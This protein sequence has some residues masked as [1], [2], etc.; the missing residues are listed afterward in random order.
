VRYRYYVSQALLH[1]KPQ[2]GGAIRRVPA[3]EI[4]A[5]VL[6]G[7]REH[8]QASGAEPGSLPGNDRELI[9]RH[10]ERVTLHP[11]HIKLQLH[12]CADPPEAG[13][14]A[15]MAGG[16]GPAH[17]PA[18]VVTLPWSSPVPAAVK[19]IV[20]VPAHN[21][22]I[23]PGRRDQLLTAIAKAR[24]WVDGVAQGSTSF[25]AIARREGV[26]ERHVRALVP[27]AFVSPRIV[28]ALLKGTAPADLTVTA[29]ARARW[30]WA[31]QERR[32]ATHAASKGP[33][34]HPAPQFMP[35]RH[36]KPHV[37]PCGFTRQR[38]CRRA[39]NANAT[40]SSL[41]ACATA[42]HHLRRFH[43]RR[44]GREHSPRAFRDN[45]SSLLLESR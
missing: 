16:N 10:I 13:A 4:E 17:P 12:P 1:N 24:L 38:C 11:T 39:F 40:S 36:C 45:G 33:G 28:A 2:S 26:A 7:L 5:L 35:T 19:G 25:A 30:S 3:A 37:K 23:K 22:P 27:L 20:H 43:G 42:I 41:D 15:A 21:T 29:L 9:E 14:A 6:C 44:S 8:L 31:E 18:P 34:R 32:I